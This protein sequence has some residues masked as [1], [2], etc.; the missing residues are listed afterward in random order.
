[1]IELTAHL[2]A[3]LTR[4]V[5]SNRRLYREYGRPV[6]ALHEVRP[7]RLWELLADGST[8]YLGNQSDDVSQRIY[9]K[10]TDQGGKVIL[11][12]SKQRARIELILRNE[13][14]PEDIGAM[15]FERYAAY[16]EDEAG[17]RQAPYFNWVR[18]AADANDPLV[19][20]LREAIP[21]HG[22]RRELTRVVRRNGKVVRSGGK[23][24]KR[25]GQVAD[26]ELNKRVRQAL[27]DLSKQWRTG[28]A[29]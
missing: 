23:R 26:K 12:E 4:P 18:Y 20:L 3:G 19:Q 6:R 16:D 14:L 11:D 13:A 1:M 17:Q 8:L 21:Q 25:P 22:E 28:R 5:S 2:Y 24:V 29:Y 7:Q 27:N 15:S 9:F 10:T